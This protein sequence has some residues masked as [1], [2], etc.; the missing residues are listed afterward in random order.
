MPDITRN[1]SMDKTPEQFEALVKDA[2][3]Q[4]LEDIGILVAQEAENLAPFD[5]GRLARS[6]NATDPYEIERFVYGILIG[7]NVEYA[8]AHEY[9]SGLHAEDPEKRHK[10]LIEAGYWTGKSNKKALA[11]E[12]PAGPKPH[13]AFDPNT[14]KYIFRRVWHPG[15]PAKPYLR[16]ALKN[17]GPQWMGILLTRLTERLGPI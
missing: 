9:G 6:I 16:P 8:R 7:T 14:G 2:A 12:W 10:I 1:V 3:F 13:P 15:V 4:A 17:T 5:T 11:F